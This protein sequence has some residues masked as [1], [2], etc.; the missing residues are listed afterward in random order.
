M[1]EKYIPKNKITVGMTAP[2]FESPDQD[3]KMHRLADYRGQWVLLYFY[4]KDD[5][6]GCTKEA[7]MISDNLPNF[8]KL[9]TAVLGVSTDS[10]SS[11][12][13][14]AEKYDLPFTLLADE[15]KDIVQKYGVWV[16]RKF[17]GKIIPGT[18]RTSFL[19][20]PEGKIAKIYENVKPTEHADE[21]LN[22][23]KN[24]NSLYASM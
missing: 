15:K 18:K 14:F 13:K 12:K 23:L 4:P 22:D 6:P 1:A 3:G 5:T 8:E 10:V 19:I 20:S 7:C 9:E 17:I 11:H 16:E 21:V 2:D 24:F